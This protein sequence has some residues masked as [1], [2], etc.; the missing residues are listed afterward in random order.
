MPSTSWFWV[1]DSE[2]HMTFD[3]EEGGKEAQ[4]HITTETEAGPHRGLATRRRSLILVIVL[5]SCDF[6]A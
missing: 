2:A 1:C 4:K 5:P 3:P 6:A